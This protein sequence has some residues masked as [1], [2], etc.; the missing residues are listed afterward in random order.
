MNKIK[1]YVEQN[2]AGRNSRYSLFQHFGIFY[3]VW[4]FSEVFLFPFLR[5]QNIL[6]A[7]IFSLIW[8]IVVWLVPVIVILKD[9]GYPISAFLKLELDK[10]SVLLWSALSVSFITVYNVLMH[11]MTY[12]H[13]VF[14]PWLMLIQLVNVVFIAGAIEEILFRGYFLQSMMKYVSFFRA[15]FLVSL[16]FVSIHFPIW[17]I[18]A[19]R[20]GQNVISLIQLIVFILGFSFM[21]GWLLRKS[22][23]LWPCILMHMMN[24]FM[25]LA[26]A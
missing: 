3:V 21:Q 20:I 7:D 16:A 4:A 8:K 10:R 5:M 9:K 1:K 11:Y 23:S 2:N 24:N 19:N 18:N 17:Y 26:L 13:T 15:N 6:L 12:G 25:A 14:H 22:G